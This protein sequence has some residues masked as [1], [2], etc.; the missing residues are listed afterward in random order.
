MRPG[1]MDR[2]VEFGLPDLEVIP[3]VIIP[4]VTRVSSQRL[5]LTSGG[6]DMLWLLSN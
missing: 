4:A 1:R 5:H 6:R 3:A 2:K